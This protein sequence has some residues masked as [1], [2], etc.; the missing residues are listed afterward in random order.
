MTA[1]D[2]TAAPTRAESDTRYYTSFVAQAPSRASVE[3]IASRA[4]VQAAEHPEGAALM[5]RAVRAA[6]LVRLAELAVLATA[7][8]DGY[9]EWFATLAAVQVAE[10]G[11][12]TAT[13]GQ[14]TA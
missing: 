9:E 10:T 11:A 12:R 6:V 1:L 2:I 7:K 13:A 3:W 8:A 5:V 4:L 14:V